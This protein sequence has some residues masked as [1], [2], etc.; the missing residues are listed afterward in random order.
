M[1][2][3]PDST[4]GLYDCTT[5]SEIR[6]F[7]IP[8]ALAATLSPRGTYLQTFQKS[9]T[10]QE[11]NLVLWNIHTGFTYRLR[12]PGIAAVELS[13]ASGSY[14]A[15]FVAESKSYYGESKLNYLT[16]DGAHEGLVPLRK[17]GPVHDVRWSSTSSE[18]AVVYG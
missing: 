14:V 15:A 6:S 16:T 1:V 5:Y 12:I 17:E 4:I 10:P 7:A 11:K 2:I 9:S 13:K 3:K 18:F 8:N